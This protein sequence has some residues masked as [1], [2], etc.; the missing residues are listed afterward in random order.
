MWQGW[1]GFVLMA[2]ATAAL[3]GASSAPRLLVLVRVMEVLNHCRSVRP[4]A[5]SFHTH[6]VNNSHF[7]SFLL[8]RQILIAV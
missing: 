8:H 4:S 6:R 1:E 2:G 3:R 7:I 5:P